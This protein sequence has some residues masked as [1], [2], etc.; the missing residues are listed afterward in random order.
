MYRYLFIIYIL[1]KL[2][3]NL[4]RNK[5]FHGLEITMYIVAVLVEREHTKKL[6][7]KK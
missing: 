6:F 1:L 2:S 5:S 3:K 7:L 4:N